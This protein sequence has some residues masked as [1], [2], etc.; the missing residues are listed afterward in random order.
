M[1]VRNK[2]ILWGGED[3]SYI[4]VRTGAIYDSAGDSWEAT[5]V[6][7]LPAVYNHSVIWTGTEIIVWGGNYGGGYTNGGARYNPLTGVWVLTDLV[8]PACPTPREAHSAIWTGAEMIIW[9]GYNGAALGNGARYNPVGDSWVTL[10]TLDAPSARDYHTAIWTGSKMIIWGG[11]GGG[12]KGDGAV[13]DPALNT[14]TPISPTG[15]PSARYYHTAVWTG[16]EMLIWGGLGA[17]ALNDGARYNPDTDIWAPISPTDAPTIRYFHTAVWTGS[18]M[19]VWGGTDGGSDLNTGGKYNPATGLW[20]ATSVGANVPAARNRHVAVWNGA[21][22]VVWGGDAPAVSNTGGKYDPVADT[23]VPTS[24]TGDVPTGRKAFPAVAQVAPTYNISGQVTGAVVAGVTVNLTGNSTATTTTDGSGNYSF[25]GLTNGAYTVTPSKVGY[26]FSPISRSV[27]VS[28][29]S[30]PNIDFVAVVVYSISGH[31]SGATVVTVDLT[32]DSTA[33][34]T[35]DGSGNYSFPGLVDGSYTITPSK[36]GYVFSPDSSDVIVS[37]GDAVDIDFV[38]ESYFLAISSSYV[39]RF[40]SGVIEEATKHS[41]EFVDRSNFAYWKPSCNSLAS[42]IVTFVLSVYSVYIATLSNDF[43]GDLTKCL[44][45]RNGV[46]IPQTLWSLAGTNQV[47]LAFDEYDST[48]IYTF[49]YGALIQAEFLVSVASLSAIPQLYYLPYVDVFVGGNDVETEVIKTHQVVFDSSGRGTLNFVSNNN[50]GDVVITR[51]MNGNQLVLPA[52]AIQQLADDKIVINPV[53]YSDQAYYSVQYL[54]QIAQ[55]DRFADYALEWS[56]FESGVWTPYKVWN[57]KDYVPSRYYN[58]GYA[59]FVDQ[60]KLRITFS[61]V[62]DKDVVNLR[63]VG[64]YNL[65]P[66]GWDMGGGNGQE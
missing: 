6:T 26:A 36:G 14:W 11:Y 66:Y 27:T 47:V 24:I 16:T 29:A 53:Y 32:G 23:W 8:S 42:E 60:I 56:C 62:L 58:M 43:D 33:T 37:G 4:P 51:I 13:Y 38:A 65:S 20:A 39:R 63:A 40:F 1:T 12:T 19:I 55:I 2:M 41:L 22:M 34:T 10:P 49:E 30:T 50:P 15:A 9:G 31:V 35:T 48:A 61:N 46:P 21:E 28:G 59:S 7:A 52:S 17:G 3:D 54:A 5:A 18:E 45:M 57:G 25:H 64:I 44:L